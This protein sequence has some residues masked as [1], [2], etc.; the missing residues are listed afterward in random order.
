MSQN[1]LLTLLQDSTQAGVYHLPRGGHAAVK[2][3]AETAGFACFD[4][5]FGDAG[6]IDTVLE[7]LGNDLDFPEWYGRNFDALKD[8]LTDCS[9]CEAA[10]Y[11]LII[12]HAEILHTQDPRAFHTLNEVFAT[13]IAEWRS[14]DSPMWVFYDIRA[15]GLATLPTLA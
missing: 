7:R 3:A 10:G 15:D 14:Q 8:C 12:A 5:D 2:A 11:V 9:W 4:V 1:D 6:R 13:A